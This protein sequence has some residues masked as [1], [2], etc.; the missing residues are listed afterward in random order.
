MAPR[1]HFIHPRKPTQTLSRITTRPVPARSVLLYT[2]VSRCAVWQRRRLP[3]RR[4]PL[5]TRGQPHSA[6]R[7]NPFSGGGHSA[8]LPAAAP[9]VSARIDLLIRAGDRRARLSDHYRTGTAAAVNRHPRLAAAE[10]CLRPTEDRLL[11]PPAAGDG[12]CVFCDLLL[13]V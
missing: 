12:H 8:P 4:R 1:L 10:P 11:P 7:P 3:T 9:L 2:R 6:Q 5:A 13:V